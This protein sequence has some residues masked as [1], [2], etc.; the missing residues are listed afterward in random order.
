MLGRRGAKPGD[1]LYLGERTLVDFGEVQG[2][3]DAARPQ[4]RLVLPLSNMP[5]FFPKGQINPNLFRHRRRSQE[6]AAQGREE[7]KSRRMALKRRA[8]VD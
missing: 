1:S 2:R 6:V 7:M 8:M 4:T 5:R 3:R